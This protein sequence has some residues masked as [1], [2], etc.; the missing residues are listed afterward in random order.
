ML[1][2]YNQELENKTAKQMKFGGSWNDG[3]LFITETELP[4]T[5]ISL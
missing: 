3:G 2:P 4:F 5:K 1:K